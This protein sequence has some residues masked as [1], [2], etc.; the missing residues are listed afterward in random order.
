MLYEASCWGEIEAFLF[1]CEKEFPL[2]SAA[3]APDKVRLAR[4]TPQHDT[5]RKLGVLTSDSSLTVYLGVGI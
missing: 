4:T 3:P 2:T 5:L 1:G